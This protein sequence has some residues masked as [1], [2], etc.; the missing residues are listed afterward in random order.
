MI[1]IRINPTTS[2]SSA[3]SGRVLNTNVSLDF[4]MDTHKNAPIDNW[5]REN[6]NFSST[7]AIQSVEF[8]RFLVKKNRK[9]RV[10]ISLK[11]EDKV[12]FCLARITTSKR[13]S[14]LHPHSARGSDGL[15]I[16]RITILSEVGKW[17]REIQGR[18][19]IGT[20]ERFHLAQS[21]NGVIATLILDRNSGYGVRFNKV[22]K[23][24]LDN[25]RKIPRNCTGSMWYVFDW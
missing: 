25:W 12:E 14:R 23:N 11:N 9:R 18:N 15:D 7:V 13:D 10:K 17:F 6:S 1:G 3:R 21:I 4:K 8:T 2:R 5:S 24:R 16:T 19:E 20:A 22:R